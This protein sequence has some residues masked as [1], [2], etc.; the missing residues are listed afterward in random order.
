M[1]LKD[2]QIQ[3]L[4]EA[5]ADG[6]PDHALAESA[7]ISLASVKRYRRR[8]ELPTT[9]VTARRGKLGERLFAEAARR[10][11]LPLTWRDHETAPYDLR[12]NGLRVDVKA[13]RQRPDGTWRYRLHTKRRSFHGEYTYPKDIAADCDVVAFVCLFPDE[14]EPLIYLTPSA[15]LPSTVRLKVGGGWDIHWDAWDIF[16]TSPVLI[17]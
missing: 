17:A 16:R 8:L 13:S 3:R 7:G 12:V 6:L 15:G 1:A 14:R 11:G 10:Q 2:I 4:L 5:H 9:S